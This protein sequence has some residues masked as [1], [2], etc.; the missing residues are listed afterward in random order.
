MIALG[1]LISCAHPPDLEATRGDV[2][3]A[4]DGRNVYVVAVEVFAGQAANQVYQAAPTNA[5]T[6]VSYRYLGRETR[7]AVSDIEVEVVATTPPLLMLTTPGGVWSA[8]VDSVRVD[9]ENLHVTLSV[10]REA[11]E[12]ASVIWYVLPEAVYPPIV[13]GVTHLL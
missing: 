4:S 11:N 6:E 9:A 3:A 2:H 5:A 7:S 10:S 1:T 8:A 12:E 13:V